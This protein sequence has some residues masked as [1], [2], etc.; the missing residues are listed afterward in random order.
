[1]QRG[2]PEP[3]CYVVLH[4]QLFAFLVVLGLGSRFGSIDQQLQFVHRLLDFL[5]VEV[6][7]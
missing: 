6:E 4:Q 3:F 5:L 7:I 1:M 2:H